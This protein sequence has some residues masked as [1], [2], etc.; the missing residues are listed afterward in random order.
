MSYFLGAIIQGQARV[1]LTLLIML[2]AA[3]ITAEILERLRQPAVV[4]EILAGVMIGPS[5][6]G[7]VAPTEDH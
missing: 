2:A 7:W 5:L 4:G 1:L 3:K 6:F